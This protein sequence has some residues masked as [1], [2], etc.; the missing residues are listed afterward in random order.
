MHFEILVEGQTELTAL[1]ILMPKIVGDYDVPHTWCIHKHQGI[2]KLPED[3]T[4][5]PNKLDRSLLHNFP[6]KLR[7]Y[8]KS[9]SDNEI[10]I[11]LLDLDDVA[12][13]LAF[14]NEILSAKDYCFNEPNLLVRF[15]IEELEAWFLG[16]IN[17]IKKAFVTSKTKLLNGYTQD[18]ICGT[19][20]LLADIVHPGGFAKLN[21]F[22]KRSIRILEEK[23]KW[24]AKIAPNMNIENNES[25]SFNCF[26]EGILNSIK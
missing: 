23:R 22:G 16:D 7:A 12:D 4:A 26:K 6:S 3:L 10:I 11:L 25:A 21:S 15:A 17:A 5:I 8:S 14:K 2:G 18:S 20:E 19:W 9:M 13:C 1:S 24:A